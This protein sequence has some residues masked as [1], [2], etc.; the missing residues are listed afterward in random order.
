LK[1]NP[2]YPSQYHLIKLLY[3]SLKPHIWKRPFE[4]GSKFKYFNP[5]ALLTQL[6]F[7]NWHLNLSIQPTFHSPTSIPAQ[8][9]FPQCLCRTE[10]TNYFPT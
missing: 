8:N 3:F 9:M 6:Y 5:C 4:K 1:K 10:A 2:P 7:K